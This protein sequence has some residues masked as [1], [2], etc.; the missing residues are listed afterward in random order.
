MWN[1]CAKL[2]MPYKLFTVLY[3]LQ[4][5]NF[6]LSRDDAVEQIVLDLEAELQL[7]LHSIDS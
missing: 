4:L 1:P 3:I 7:L 2:P 5:Q 6:G